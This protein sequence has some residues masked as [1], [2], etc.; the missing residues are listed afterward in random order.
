MR[1]CAG[2][3]REQADRGETSGA[4]LVKQ[5]EHWDAKRLDAPLLKTGAG[6]VG[7]TIGTASLA[8]PAMLIPGANTYAARLRR[9]ADGSC[10]D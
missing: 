9:W 7:S 10:F 1:A 6:R 4:G 5:S 2:S 8:A 3:R